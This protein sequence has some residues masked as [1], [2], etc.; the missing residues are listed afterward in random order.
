MPDTLVVH[1]VDDDPDVVEFLKTIL[2]R[3]GRET[4]TYAS[5]QSLL[6]VGPA[7]LPGC[8]VT[9]V[10]MPGMTG[11]ELVKRLGE[12]G[13]GHPVIVLTGHGRVE[14]AIEAMRAGA[15]DFLEKPFESE[16]LLAAVDKAMAARTPERDRLVAARRFRH[17]VERLSRREQQVLRGIE[18]G[19]PTKI[20]AYEL[21]ISPRT[22]EVY[23]NNVMSKT[24]AKTLAELVRLSTSS[25]TH[26]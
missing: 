11:V 2:E 4:R 5:A 22:V 6:A 17:V 20:I 21:G 3:A 13:I 10:R 1:V 15:V 9:D 12:V 24:G 14:L 25:G 7:L 26:G 18:D 8:I 19:K 23:R 16:R